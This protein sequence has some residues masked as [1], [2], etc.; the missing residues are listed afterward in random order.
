[1]SSLK[2]TFQI[3]AFPGDEGVAAL[4]TLY[5]FSRPFSLQALMDAV[6][7]ELQVV[8]WRDL[9]TAEH[10]A[11]RDKYEALDYRPLSLSI[12]GSPDDPLYAAVMVKR[13]KIITTKSFVNLDQAG[14][15]RTFDDM[16]SQG[17]GPFIITATGPSGGAVFAG[18]FR[19][20]SDI[21]LTRSNLSQAD[22]IDLNRKQHDAGAILVWADAF[23]TE[24]DSRYCAIWG[25]NPERIAWNIDAVDE[26][27]DTLKQRSDAMAS[28]GARPVLFA[29]TPAG[30]IMAAFVD[31]QIGAWASRSNMTSAGY[32]TEK[33]NQA[34]KKLYPVYISASGTGDSAR[35]AAIFAT[36]EQHRP[37]VF[38]IRGPEPA[39]LDQANRVKAQALDQWME[40][41]VRAH[42]FRGAAMAIV[43]GTRLVYAKGYTLAETEPYYRDIHPTT[44]FRMA[45]VSKAFCGVSV[46]KALADDPQ[47]S[48]N[49]KMQA[50]LGLTP[51]NGSNAD[52]DFAD[53]TVRHLLES[54]SGIDQGSLRAIVSEVKADLNQTQPLTSP[55]AA[56]RIAARSMPGKPGATLKNGKQDTHYGSTDYFLLGLVAAKLAGVT[57]FESALKKLLLDPLKMTRT[58]GSRSRV[59]DRVTDEA[60]HHMPALET[61]T[62]AVHNDRRI[63]PLQYGDENYEVYDGAGGLSSAVV[64]VARMCAMLSCRFSNPLFTDNFLG[65]LLSDAVAATSGGSEHGYY[66]FD[67]AIG[68]Y[69]SVACEKKGGNPSVGAGFSA[70]TASRFIVIARNGEK[71]EDATLVNWDTELAAIAATIDWKGGDLFPHFDMPALGP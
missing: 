38:R 68:A 9:N 65:A 16:V 23:G 3:A 17:F 13:P 67:W 55:Q 56:S 15:Q 50:I 7:F 69:P 42:N 25:P 26:A 20:M 57:G 12:Y 31:S 62:S 64:D 8:D 71:V 41:Y 45:S 61:G 63:V 27:G 22:F 43:D 60:L 30:R 2:T 37:R 6:S 33:E 44:L 21:P 1:M 5:G 35:F 54:N 24:D 53:I 11:R 51:H 59:E 10:I 36:Q 19:A 4:G 49:S 70:H 32:K 52:H 14:Y 58:R 47:E 66:G 18:S 29:V 34:V 48:H 28:V 40:D 46:W 39:G